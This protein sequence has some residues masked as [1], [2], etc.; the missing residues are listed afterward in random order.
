MTR[1]ATAT[2]TVAPLCITMWAPNARPAPGTLPLG[3]LHVLDLG[4]EAK[5]LDRAAHHGTRALELVA[6]GL[7]GDASQVVEVTGEEA[8]LADVGETA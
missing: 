1:G 7:E 5:A 3:P 4:M 2:R 6:L 8:G